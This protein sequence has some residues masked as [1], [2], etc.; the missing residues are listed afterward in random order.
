MKWFKFWKKSG[1]NQTYEEDY[2]EINDSFYKN[3]EE[4]IK[5]A[6]EQVDEWIETT[7]DRL[8]THYCY[9]FEEVENP[10]KSG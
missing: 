2:F 3:K 10:P 7:G 5:A 1:P 8:D 6:H 9:G 4:V